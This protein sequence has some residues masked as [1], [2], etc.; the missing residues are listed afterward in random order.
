MEMDSI[1]NTID[2][3]AVNSTFNGAP[4]FDGS[5]TFESGGASATIAATSASSLG[6]GQGASLADLRR[7]GALALDGGDLTAAQSALERARS[8]INT[9]R[10]EAGAFSKYT[11][12]ARLSGLAVGAE[13]IASARSSIRDADMAQEIASLTRAEIMMKAGIA[14][15]NAQIEAG[16]MIVDIFG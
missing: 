3:I 7:G 1:V 15:A 6:N 14:A 11:I 10:A 2:R 16:G 13:N 8:Q 5:M 4:I 12:G 9:M